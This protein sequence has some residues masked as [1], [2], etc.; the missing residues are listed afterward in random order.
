MAK[1]FDF[2]PVIYHSYFFKAYNG[3]E[4]DLLDCAFKG[5]IAKE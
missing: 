1:R 3:S 2:R 5:F 4:G